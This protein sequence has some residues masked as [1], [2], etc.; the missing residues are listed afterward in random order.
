MDFGIRGRRFDN[1]PSKTFTANSLK[2][3]IEI[4]QKTKTR[5]NFG[6]SLE[7]W[8]AFA[9][10]SAHVLFQTGKSY[11][12]ELVAA[13]KLTAPSLAS[14]RIRAGLNVTTEMRV[15]FKN[16]IYNIHAVL[17]GATHEYVDLAVEAGKNNG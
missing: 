16:K 8:Q 15:M 13:D 9:K 6:Q 7:T 3:R 5:D 4:Q 17:P 1:K 14:V 12:S 11:N 2:D 10:V